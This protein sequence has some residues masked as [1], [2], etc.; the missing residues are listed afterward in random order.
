MSETRFT[1]T[2]RPATKGSWR[3]VD[4]QRTGRTILIPQL[5][6]SKPWEHAVAL[7]A[8]AAHKG[9]PWEKSVPVSLSVMF[10][11]K[12][13]ASHF[14]TKAG[15][16]DFTRLKPSAPAHPSTQ[17]SGD[18]DKLVR[19]IGDALS[20]IVYHDDAQI[21]SIEADKLYHGE[22]EGVAVTVAGMK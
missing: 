7:A 2:G 20:G 8:R 9:D 16:P 18:L 1:V 21:V 13:P 19:A 11:F 6:R 22:G 3:P 15:K 5:R 14:R 12:R 17:A 10:Y 4:N